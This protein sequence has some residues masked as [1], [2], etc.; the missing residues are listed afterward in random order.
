MGS[1]DLHIIHMSLVKT[2]WVRRTLFYL[3]HQYLNR[4][5]HQDSMG[6]LET[7]TLYKLAGLLAHQYV[8]RIHICMGRSLPDLDSMSS[9]A[10][11]KIHNVA[12]LLAH[13]YLCRIQ[14]RYCTCC[15]PPGLDSYSNTVLD[16]ADIVL[17]P[18]QKF[19]VFFHKFVRGP[20]SKYPEKNSFV[21]EYIST[22]QQVQDWFKKARWRNDVRM[23][24]TCRKRQKFFE[25][26]ENAFN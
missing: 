8:R 10:T 12:G 11:H 7:H 23:L 19:F 22:V 21:Y 14:S 26:E 24:C 5:R 2:G 3:Q 1:L 16:L 15:S 6:S 9:Q 4:R 13:Q 25:I 17:Y 20:G 18:G